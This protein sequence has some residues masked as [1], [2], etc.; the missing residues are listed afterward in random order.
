MKRALLILSTLGLLIANHAFGQTPAPA[1]PKPVTPK[2]ATTETAQLEAKARVLEVQVRSLQSRVRYKGA[3]LD[4]DSKGFTEFQLE[5]STLVFLAACSNIEPYLE[6]HKITIDVS[7]PYAIRFS[8]LSGTL[9]YGKTPE[10][11]FERTTEVTTTQSL[12]PGVW[13]PITIIVNPSKPEDLRYLEL[14]LRS[15]SAGSR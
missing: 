4:C 13:T 11:S 12:A 8:T 10:Q 3:S 2:P 9:G 5:T 1:V 6:G 7:N 14:N 15:A